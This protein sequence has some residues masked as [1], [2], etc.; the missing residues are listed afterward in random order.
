MRRGAHRRLRVQTP[1]FSAHSTPGGRLDH[2]LPSLSSVASSVA[3]GGFLSLSGLKSPPGS[4]GDHRPISTLVLEQDQDLRTSSSFL[5][6]SLSKRHE[7][8][9]WSQGHSAPSCCGHAF[10]GQTGCLR[11][12]PGAGAPS[13]PLRAACCLMAG[14][15]RQTPASSAR[16][17]QV[18]FQPELHTSQN[19]PPVPFV[20]L[21]FP[22]SL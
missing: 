15:R 14:G 6:N 4:W 21:P 12:S 1:P 8:Q 20:P 2:G 11:A 22:P 7:T 9:S 13:S 5:F 19:A 10:P 16:Q 17:L 3:W 18:Y